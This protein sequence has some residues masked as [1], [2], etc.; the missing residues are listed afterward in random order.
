MWKTFERVK[1]VKGN[2][3]TYKIIK[4]WTIGKLFLVFFFVFD[5]KKFNIFSIKAMGI[6]EIA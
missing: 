2:K 3:S 6:E 4:M 1:T 5:S